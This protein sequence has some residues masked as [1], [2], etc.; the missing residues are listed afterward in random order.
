MYLSF[1]VFK[2]QI[3]LPAAL[4]P[5]VHS[6][7]NRSDYQRRKVMFLESRARPVRR[8]DNLTAIC[9]DNVGSSM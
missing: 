1:E 8:A 6:A 3:F 5:D 7:S 2:G 4:G 9:L